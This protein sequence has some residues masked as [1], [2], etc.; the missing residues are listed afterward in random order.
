MHT[1]SSSFFLKRHMAYSFHCKCPLNL[2]RTN[3]T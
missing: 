2:C 1:S 3:K